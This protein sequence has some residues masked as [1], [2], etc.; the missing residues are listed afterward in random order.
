MNSQLT[1][2]FSNWGNVTGQA[3]SQTKYPSR[4]SGFC[5]GILQLSLPLAVSLSFFNGDHGINCSL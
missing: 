1:D 5:P 4:Y 3:I 2:P